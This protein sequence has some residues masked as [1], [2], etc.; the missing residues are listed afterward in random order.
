[1]VPSENQAKIC[2]DQ[3]RWFQMYIVDD[4]LMIFLNLIICVFLK[5]GNKVEQYFLRSILQIFLTRGKKHY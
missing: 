5:S 1:M 2:E 4:N 3:L